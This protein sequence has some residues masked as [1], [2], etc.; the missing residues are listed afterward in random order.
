MVWSI[1]IQQCKGMKCSE[2]LKS[3]FSRY[4]SYTVHISLLF[5]ELEYKQ[6]RFNTD[7][8]LGVI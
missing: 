7:Y 1:V 8:M 3:L 2:E 6:N 5:I 4:L